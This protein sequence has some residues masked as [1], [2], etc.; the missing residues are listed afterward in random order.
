MARVGKIARCPEGIREELNRK[1]RAGKLGPELLPWL[2][3]LPEVRAVIAEFFP[4]QLISAQN[5]S[6]WRQGGFAEW[7]EKQDKTHRIREMAGFAAKLTEANSGRLAEGAAAI[8]GGKILELLE[9]MDASPEGGSMEQLQDVVAAVASL[10]A[11]DIAQQRAGIDQAKL[12]QKDEELALAREKFR[13][14][15]CELF[16]RWAT[17]QRAIEAATSGG[18]NA[19]KIERLGEL[20]FG[21]EWKK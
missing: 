8:A 3:G 2:N 21:E 17:D 19:A 1:L 13:R 15:T 12:K 20:M 9:T 5:L 16:I 18:D 6:D 4:G 14:E 10:R 7:E 11:G